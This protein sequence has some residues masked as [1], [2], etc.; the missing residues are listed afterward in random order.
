MSQS[1]KKLFFVSMTIFI[2]IVIIVTIPTVL[3]LT[4]SNS[5]NDMTNTTL[6]NISPNQ[7][8]PTTM[9]TTEQPS[10]IFFVRSIRNK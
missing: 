9:G 8:V 4:K 6:S 2:L 1:R 3:I 7:S 10:H 5:S